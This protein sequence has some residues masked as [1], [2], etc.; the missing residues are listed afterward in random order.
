MSGTLLSLYP[1]RK[2]KFKLIKHGIEKDVDKLSS[3]NVYLRLPT[4][5]NWEA[6]PE[7]NLIN[8]VCFLKS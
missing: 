7:V 6:I 2:D 8:I 5:M 4:D 1:A 3:A